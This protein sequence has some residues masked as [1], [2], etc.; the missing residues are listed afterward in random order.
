MS[1][2]ITKWLQDT[3]REAGLD[4]ATCGLNGAVPRRVLTAQERLD[5]READLAVAKRQVQQ[6]REAVRGES[7]L[8]ITAWVLLV[9]TTGALVHF[10]PSLMAWADGVWR[11]G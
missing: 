6:E 10:W 2:A 9:L 1:E 4:A 8:V 5:R 11:R 3:E 7:R